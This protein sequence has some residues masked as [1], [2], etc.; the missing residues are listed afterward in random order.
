MKSRQAIPAIVR[1]RKLAVL[2]SA[3]LAFALPA[4]AVDE[5]LLKSGNRVKGTIIAQSKDQVVMEVGEGAVVFPK[6]AIR[7]IYDGITANL[8]VSQM[9]A[10][11]ELPI[12]WIP[13]SDLYAE[14]WVTDLEN[15]PA[16]PATSGLFKNVP[17]L[18]FRANDRYRLNIYGDPARPAAIEIGHDSRSKPSAKVIGHCREFLVSYL[19]DLEQIKALYDLDPSG[20]SRT[21]GKLTVQAA[22]DPRA[23]SDEGW[24]LLVFDENRLAAARAAT[25]EEFRRTSA[26]YVEIMRQATGDQTSWQKWELADALQRL[27]PMEN[28]EV[29]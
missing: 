11:D 25:P 9:L 29:R 17:Y 13:L 1:Q 6:R 16:T 2:V 27:I 19:T 15:V 23:S 7:R 4:H 5:V 18:S 28:I 21:E 10:E 14:D 20:G 3:T 12:W 24:G 22:L 8:P 26:G